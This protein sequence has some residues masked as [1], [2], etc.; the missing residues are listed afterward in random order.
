MNLMMIAGMRG[1]Q[2]VV[3]SGRNLRAVVAASLGFTQPRTLAKS[4]L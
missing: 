4:T 1:L 2:G 3:N